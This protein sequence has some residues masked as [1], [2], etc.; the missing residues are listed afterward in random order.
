LPRA[1]DAHPRTDG[2]AIRARLAHADL[3]PVVLRSV[4]DLPIQQQQH[5]TA[6]VRRDDVDVAVVV[7]IAERGA[8][9]DIVRLRERRTSGGRRLLEAAAARV[10]KELVLHAEGTRLATL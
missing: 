3:E 4:F 2:E 5:W 7:E 10:V 1:L 8:A 9:P 6:V